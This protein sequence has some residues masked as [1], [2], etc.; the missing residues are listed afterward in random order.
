[1]RRLAGRRFDQRGIALSSPL[2]LLSAAA[3]VLAGAAFVATNGPR[4]EQ[5]AQVSA[6]TSSAT[7]SATRPPYR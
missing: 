4:D 2:A 3:V 1:M 6:P 5:P 7:S